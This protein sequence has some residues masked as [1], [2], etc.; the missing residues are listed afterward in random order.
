MACS[1][2]LPGRFVPTTPSLQLHLPNPQLAWSGGH[3]RPWQLTDA[4]TLVRAWNDTE[5]G[6]WNPVPSDATIRTAEKWIK[7]CSGRLARA[8]AIDLCI[9]A[10]HPDGDVV[11]GEVGLA[12]VDHERRGA[13]VGYWLLPEARGEGHASGAVA[14]FAEWALSDLDLAV[15]VARCHERNA[16]SHRV[17]QRAG[18]TRAGSDGTGHELWARRANDVKVTSKQMP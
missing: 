14:A 5:V 4:P 1:T 15:V 16:A 2:P 8:S 17:A 11:V 3:L 18:F 9:V 6:R 13:Q 10:A 7:G 12:G